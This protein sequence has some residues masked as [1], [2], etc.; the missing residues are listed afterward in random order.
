[1]YPIIAFRS[2]PFPWGRGVGRETSGKRVF[3]DAR[4]GTC[5]DVFG[6]RKLG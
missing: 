1:M 3:V 4:D 6:E 5:G 2:V